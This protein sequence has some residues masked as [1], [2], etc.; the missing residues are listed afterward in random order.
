MD[1]KPFDRLPLLEWASWWNQTLDR[2]HTEELPAEITDHHDVSRH[3]G[4]DLYVQN[5]A[6]AVH[7][8]CPFKPPRH[9]AGI[10]EEAGEDLERI[11]P[12]LGRWPVIPEKV[13]PW[14]KR[15]E[16]GDLVYWLSVD[17]FFW[18]PRTILG[19]ERHMYA[20]YEMPDVIHRINDVQADWIIRYVDELCKLIQ[21]DFMTFAEDLSYNH[22][23]MLSKAL[24]DEF[25]LPYYQRVIPHLKK[26]GIR[27]IIDS[28]G[29]VTT[30]VP[31]FIEAGI[32]GVLP[33]ER[34]A[35]VD[36]AKIKKEYPDFKMIGGYDKMVMNKGDEAIRGEFERLLPVARQGG[37]LISCDH[38]T[39][40]GVSYKDYL[41]YMKRFREYAEKAARR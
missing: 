3:F 6:R 34:Q 8:D 5:W 23:P 21:P 25:L 12:F 16:A 41:I 24:F 15:H 20:F 39:P 11:L 22:G 27:V 31:W 37:F 13:E 36:V 35:G 40:P 28:D 7:W 30:A 32:E 10:F 18:V 17:G 29:D 14:I 1:G 26:R 38:Q 9:G 4:L 33:L 19:I 2:W